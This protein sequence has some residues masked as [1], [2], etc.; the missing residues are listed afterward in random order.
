MIR[1]FHTFMKYS[2]KI[3]YNQMKRLLLSVFALTI[4]LSVSAQSDENLLVNEGDVVPDFKVTMF[5]GSVID[6]KDLKGKVVLVNFWATWCPHCV[7]ELD[8]AQKEIIDRFKDKNFVF[9]PIS[10]EDPIEKIEQF[11]K[12]KGF[13]FPMGTDFKREIYSKFAKQTIPRNFLV[14]ENG[15]IVYVKTG[16]NEE[17]LAELIAAIEKYVK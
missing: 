7:K 13:T 6:I 14:D 12:D 8:V 10:R 17:L 5:D 2:Q 15:K 11:R 3:K 1:F 9:L 16:F 4:A